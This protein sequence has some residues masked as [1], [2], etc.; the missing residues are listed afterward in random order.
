MNKLGKILTPH[1]I[2]LKHAVLTAVIMLFFAG[3]TLPNPEISNVQAV[4]LPHVIS[5][6]PSSGPPGTEVR[7]HGVFFTPQTPVIIFFDG[8][9]MVQTEPSGTNDS[10]TVYFT[11]PEATPYGIHNVTVKNINDI[12]NLR[13]TVSSSIIPSPYSN[14]TI[15]GP[16]NQ[17]T[18]STPSYTNAPTSPPT[19]TQTDSSTP[20]ISPQP[21]LVK[22]VT[23]SGSTVNLPITGNI[24][25][26]QIASCSISTNQTSSTATVSFNITGEPGITGFSN[27][28]IPKS[29]VYNS[30][31]PQIYIDGKLCVNQGYTEDVNN[32]YVWYTTHFSTHQI[33]ITFS[34]SAPTKL[35]PNSE[36]ISTLI[37]VTISVVTASVLIAG[38]LFYRK[39]SKQR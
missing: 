30:V 25:A 1:G 5:V 39:I 19:P 9:E 37:I 27:I 3:L 20:T 24:T 10:I 21:A 15:I 31:Q 2:S 32:F 22:A 33:S 34:A 16:V 14:E 17:P 23:E 4:S 11:I 28:T 26:T 12:S 7:V 13:F 18:P 6:Y 29:A 38:M 36:L 8:Q 35:L